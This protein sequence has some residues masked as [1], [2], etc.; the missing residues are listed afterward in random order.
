MYKRRVQKAR[1]WKSWF[2]LRKVTKWRFLVIIF[3]VCLVVFAYHPIASETWSSDDGYESSDLEMDWDEISKVVNE[4]G[5]DGKFN[6][7]GILN[8][9]IKEI[10]EWKQLIPMANQTVLSLDYVSSN[11]T[12]ETLYPEW[13]DEEEEAQVP[14]CPSLPRVAPP[15]QRLDLI[16]VK[17]P[18]HKY[19]WSRNVARLHL[20][21]AAADLAAAHKGT[22]PLHILLATTCF[23]VPNLFRCEDLVTR[24]RSIWL[25]KPNLGRLREKLRLPIGSCQ[26]ALP[27]IGIEEQ[28]YSVSTKRRR[29]AYATVLHSN[30]VYVCGAIVVAQS[31]RMSGSDRDLVIL[32]DEYISTSHRVG[33]ESAGWEVRTI[34][35]I[36]NPKAEKDAYNEWNYSKFRLWQLTDY[37]KVIFIDSDLLVLRNTDFLFAMPELSAT[38]NHEHVFN[39][40]VMVLEPSNCTFRLLMDHVNDFESYNGGDQGYLN[41]VFTWWHRIPRRANFLKHF[42][43]G[44]DAAA[45]ERKSHMFESD[46]PG[47][48]VVHYL[49]NKP[50]MCFRDYDCNWNVEVLREFASD[51]AHALWWR[52]HDAMPGELQRYCLLRALQKA[53]LE[54]DR[55]EAEMGNFS[56]AH[57]RIRVEDARLQTCIDEDCDWRERLRH[58]GGNKT[59]LARMANLNA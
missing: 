49:G 39:S 7:I 10:H 20:Q 44:D 29:E 21:I 45:K 14:V 24:R 40:G 11:A 51:T 33:L 3:V 30:Y 23:P 34:Q 1:N 47:M 42:W 27:L 35:R 58:W 57:W 12:W 18:C 2:K 25:Y 46:P 31:I 9:N 36:R 43:A 28:R 56:D 38:G 55:R 8:F 48:Y 19:K 16:A 22:Q 4:L 5:E 59:A 17:L 15:K 37:D 6:H 26:L 54:L 50:W 32:V 53:Q 41:E 52:V 13:I